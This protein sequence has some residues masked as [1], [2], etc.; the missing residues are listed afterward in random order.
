MLGGIFNYR[1]HD[2]LRYVKA[3]VDSGRFGKITCASVYVPWWRSEE[4]YKGSW[5]GT[6]KLDGGGALMNQAI[7]MIDILQY[8]MGPVDSLQSYT[9]TLAHEIEV[10]DT[11]VCVLR[12]RNG[13]LG[14]IHGTTASYPGQFRRLEITG[15]KG[16]VVQEE[17]SFKVWRFADQS[18]GD[19]EIASRFSQIEGGG[20]VSDPAAIPFEPHA[21]NF[22]AFLD[23][24]ESGS[25]FQIDGPEAR[26]AVEIIL[27]I[28]KSSNEMKPFY[29]DNRELS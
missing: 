18:E 22:A 23:S 20:G 15:T 5:H 4:Y 17:N 16:T 25:P 21:R 3:A 7:H 29:F 8:L 19:N 11:A 10:E 14:I 2:S 1:F 26:K 28:Y 12:F 13:A 24:I 9:A 27:A 6:R